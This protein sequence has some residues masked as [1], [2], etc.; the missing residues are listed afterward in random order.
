MGQVGRELKYFIR[1]ATK[2][3]VPS[4][5]NI[6][7]T[8]ACELGGVITS[9]AF[10]AIVKSKKMILVAV[11][12]ERKVVG[13]IIG[14]M[15]TKGVF[16]NRE[17]AVLPQHRLRGVGGGLLIT[18]LKYLKEFRIELKENPY[19]SHKWFAEV[20]LQNYEAVELYKALHF[21]I[22]GVLRKHTRNKQDMGIVAFY[23]DEMPIPKFWFETN[24]DAAV[25]DD[26]D[27][28]ANPRDIEIKVESVSDSFIGTG[29]KHSPIVGEESEQLLSSDL[30]RFFKRVN[31]LTMIGS[32]DSCG[33]TDVEV[34]P[35][36]FLWICDKCW[37]QLEK[38]A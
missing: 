37:K 15:I 4:L 28:F 1:W 8:V 22:E 14:G 35:F 23:L 16:Y 24:P 31:W 9:E 19:F 36:D 5:Y 25:I 27:V 18:L 10:K 13:F 29:I 6:S 12:E 21:P 7:L 30:S 33:A 2:D 3:D 32:C 17:L 11:S 38:E 34:F 26:N 20:P